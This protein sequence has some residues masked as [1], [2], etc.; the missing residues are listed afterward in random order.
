M[1]VEDWIKERRTIH[2]A[3]TEGPW[4]YQ[5]ES[6][7]MSGETWT[8]RREGVAGIR[9]SVVEYQHGPGNADAIVDAHNTLPTVLTALEK[10]LELHQPVEVEPS[11]TICNACSNAIGAGDTLLRYMPTEEW[12]CPTVQA[13]E[14]AI[15]E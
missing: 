9:M 5:P 4:S 6:P 8:L 14:G 7:T 1:K 13:I 15:N 12:P 10:V 2:D 3:A 11:D